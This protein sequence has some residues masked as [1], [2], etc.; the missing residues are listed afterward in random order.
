MIGNG[1]IAPDPD[2]LAPL[3]DLPLPKDM[4]SLKRVIGVFSHYSNWIQNFSQTLYPLS[5]CRTFPIESLAKE[6]F[7]TIKKNIE[8]ATVKSIDEAVPFVVETDASDHSIAA[9][10]NQNG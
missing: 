6:A 4:K 5:S 9:S 3:R 8:A 7:E 10:Q 2:R 1:E